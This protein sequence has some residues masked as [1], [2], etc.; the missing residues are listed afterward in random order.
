[1]NSQMS[2]LDAREDLRDL[3]YHLKGIV[4]VQERLRSLLVCLDA[5]LGQSEEA[6]QWLATQIELE[7]FAHL[8]HHTE[9][10]KQP[11][12]DLLQELYGSL[13]GSLLSDMETSVESVDS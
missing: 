5:A 10:L 13:D 1:M 2:S 8:A 12:R 4:E 7:V 3:R 6:S 11:L 9:E